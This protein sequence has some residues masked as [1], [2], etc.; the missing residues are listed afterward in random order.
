MTEGE[1][2]VRVVNIPRN[3]HNTR[4]SQEF[5]RLVWTVFLPSKQKSNTPNGRNGNHLLARIVFKIL[6]SVKTEA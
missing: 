1:L 6:Q 3:I 5:A 4:V 2:R